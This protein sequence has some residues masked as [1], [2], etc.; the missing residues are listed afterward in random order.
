MVVP[1]SLRNEDY[2]HPE[3]LLGDMSL[4]PDLLD[5]AYEEPPTV[6]C[7]LSPLHQFCILLLLCPM[8]PSLE[9]LCSHE[10]GATRP[11]IGKPPYPFPD[12]RI[13]WDSVVHRVG[14]NIPWDGVPWRGHPAV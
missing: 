4:P 9:V 2:Y 13:R 12:L 1:S 8:K 14:I 6:P 3:Q 11:A 7:A 5:E 10:G